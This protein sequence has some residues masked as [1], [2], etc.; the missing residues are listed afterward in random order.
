MSKSGLAGARRTPTEA[1][2]P[3]FGQCGDL[4]DLSDPVDSP[5]AD[6]CA[7]TAPGPWA[8]AAP[9]PLKPLA[10]AGG[11]A[12]EAKVYEAKVAKVIAVAASLAGPTPHAQPHR[13]AATAQSALVAPN[14]SA[15][16][17]F[18]DFGL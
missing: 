6:G 18:A 12:W 15:E 16:L 14:Q 1:A 4:I 8:G 3:P 5:A 2:A 9:P 13:P 17:F 11:E 7:A 10:L